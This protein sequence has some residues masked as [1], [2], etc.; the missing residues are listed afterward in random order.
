MSYIEQSNRPSPASLAA[1]IGVHAGLG[2]VLIAGLTV[3]GVIKP[4]VDDAFP[5]IDFKL[6]ETPPPPE[7][8]PST[9]PEQFQAPATNPPTVP[10]PKFNVNPRPTDIRTTELILPSV[11]T[12][13][14]GPITL[15]PPVPQPLPSPRDTGVDPVSA[16]PRNDPGAWLRDSDYKSSWA[17]RDLTGVA[18]FQLDISRMGTITGCRVTGSTGHGELD[19]ATCALVQ[20]RA[21]FEPA[22]GKQGEPVAGT[23]SGAVRWELPD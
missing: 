5:V 21:K 15:D 11:P 8:E 13:Q 19:S 16:K 18:R 23:Y 10:Q 12:P 14:P 1:A 2:A 3:S 9:Q 6:P 4:P 20:K 17:R 7:P 22:R